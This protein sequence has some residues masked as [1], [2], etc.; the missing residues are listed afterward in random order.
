M[1]LKAS[2]FLLLIVVICVMAPGC[3]HTEYRQVTVGNRSSI[4]ISF[5]EVGTEKARSG[6]GYLGPSASGGKT[7]SSCAITFSQEFGVRW[8]EDSVA[9]NT[10]LNIMQYEKKKD[11]IDGFAFLYLGDGNWQVVA[12]ERVPQAN[13]PNE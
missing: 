12:Q 8:Q 4:D 1:L 5:V 11:R 13:Q 7:S 10:Q 9:R 6:F 3:A 2:L